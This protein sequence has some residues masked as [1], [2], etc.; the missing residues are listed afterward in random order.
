MERERERGRNGIKELVPA[1]VS[2]DRWMTKMEWCFNKS[3]MS[4]NKRR[5]YKKDRKKIENTG[6]PRGWGDQDKETQL[7][8]HT[9][10]VLLRIFLVEYLRSCYASVCLFISSTSC[11]IYA[12]RSTICLN[13]SDPNSRNKSGFRC[14]QAGSSKK[15]QSDKKTNYRDIKCVYSGGKF[16]RLAT[17]WEKESALAT[18]EMLA[19]SNERAKEKGKSSCYQ[20]TTK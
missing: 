6:R 7:C 14:H 2:S 19:C 12:T 10:S 20:A 15:T 8:K 1:Y 13:I 4:I 3:N 17:E 9:T 5:K 18:K 11:E 16:N